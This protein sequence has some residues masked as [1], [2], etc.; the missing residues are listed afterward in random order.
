MFYLGNNWNGN[1][2]HHNSTVFSHWYYLL[3][4]G[5]TKTNENNETY[6][7]HGI[8]LDM[9]I[10]IVMRAATVNSTNSTDYLDMRR[11]TI[12]AAFEL[13]GPCSVLADV[14]NAWDAVGVYDPAY[15]GFF[16]PN[17]Y[18]NANFSTNEPFQRARPIFKVYI[19]F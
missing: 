8:G 18:I 1:P 11:A 19:F 14:V 7:I 5:A 10:Q 3:S 16:A 4:Q 13:Y 15:T 17:T 12:D 6:F 2:Y 9:A